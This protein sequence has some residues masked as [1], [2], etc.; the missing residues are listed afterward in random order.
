M[1]LEPR[2]AVLAAE[3]ERDHRVTEQPATGITQIPMIQG[4]VLSSD[5]LEV[6]IKTEWPEVL[7]QARDIFSAGIPAFS[8]SNAVAHRRMVVEISRSQD[9]TRRNDCQFLVNGRLATFARYRDQL[10]DLLESTISDRL[11]RS[12]GNYH[13]FHAGAVARNGRGILIP[14]ASGAGKSTL[15]AA[16]SLAGFEYFS[17]EVAVCDDD[18]WLYPFP[19][20]SSIRA[21][22]WERL[23]SEFSWPSAAQTALEFGNGGHTYMRP[24]LLPERERLDGPGYTV[25]FIVLPS[26][27]SGDT[28][29]LKRIK[30]SSALTALVTQSLNLQLRGAM[31][32]ELI[33]SLVDHA[34]CYALHTGSLRRAAELLTEL[35]SS[36]AT[37][38]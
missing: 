11:A 13:L 12:L 7:S 15:V 21:G 25:D 2:A 37:K 5:A 14:A 23:G 17:D 34:E 6:V 19:K 36:E 3:S 16:L 24:M 27:H 1:T 30:K 35:T 26:H 38:P 4:S 29:D 20:I 10:I 32:F 22:G 9:P 8:H 31:G 28:T 18:R 33:A